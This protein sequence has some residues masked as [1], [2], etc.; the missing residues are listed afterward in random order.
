MQGIGVDGLAQADLVAGVGLKVV[1]SGERF[2]HLTGQGVVQTPAFVDAGQ[3]AQLGFGVAVQFLA[4]L[5]QVGPFGV[6]LAGDRDV[7]AGR[8]GDR[9]CHQGGNAREHEGAPVGA[10]GHQT[11]EQAGGGDQPV[12]GPQDPGAEPVVAA[13]V[14]AFEVNASGHGDRAKRGWGRRCP[15]GRTRE[16]L[17]GDAG[18]EPASGRERAGRTG[19]P[20]L[21]AIEVAVSALPLALLRPWCR[22]AVC[23]RVRGALR[24]P[25]QPLPRG[26]CAARRCPGRP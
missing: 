5:G 17:P 10:T 8:H 13:A 15:V 21:T 4:F 20:S 3:L 23:R 1:M 6:G 26:S 18:L 22:L 16:D 9:A 7:F 12:V 25:L 19:C 11:H 14:V 2:G 24:A